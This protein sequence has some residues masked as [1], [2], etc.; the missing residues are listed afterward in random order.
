MQMSIFQAIV[1]RTH[2]LLARIRGHVLPRSAEPVRPDDRFAILGRLVARL[3]Q[4]SSF[5]I[6]A[7]FLVS[8]DEMNQ[9]CDFT[10][11]ERLAAARHGQRDPLPMNPNQAWMLIMQLIEGTQDGNLTW[12]R[13]DESA[14]RPWEIPGRDTPTVWNAV[15]TMAS[16]TQIRVD[17]TP[18]KTGAFRI[19]RP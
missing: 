4:Q 18:G 1:V 13:F 10:N 8:R 11:G 14:L 9:F 6:G 15:L 3:E 16:P 7:T 17:I 5:R 19:D 12:T 2:V